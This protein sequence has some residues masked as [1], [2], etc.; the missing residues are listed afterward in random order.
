MMTQD[1]PV[2]FFF[3]ANTPDGFVGFHT[4]D[5]YDPRD[6]WIAYLIKSGAGTGKATFM[7]TLYSELIAMGVNVHAILCSSDPSSLDALLAPD[8]KLCVVDATAPHILE[9]IAY[10]EC[11]QL[12]PFGCCLNDSLT[13][14]TDAWY[15]EADA[16]SAAHARCCRFLAAAARLKENSVRLL[17]GAIDNEK[18]LASAARLAKRELGTSAAVRG[19]CTRRFLSAVTPAGHLFF[20]DTAAAL[21]PRLYVLQDTIGAV[22]TPYMQALCEAA[23]EAGH[24][25][26]ACPCILSPSHIEHLLIPSLG[27][28][29]LTSGPFHTVDFPV[30]RRVHATRF[31]D[32][33]YQR[34]HKGQLRFN[35]RAAASL[36]NE[37]VAASADA[38]IHH[39]RMEQRHVQGMD[40]A[41]WERIA[42]ASKERFLSIVRQRLS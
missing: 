21:C 6:G 32:E 28:G 41:C 29:F 13:E 18:L 3:G 39:D 9:P 42:E 15:E 14:H 19:R 27:V 26:I 31:I 20:S 36:I 7:R 12:V 35:R 16:C 37:A 25:V 38:K 10:G 1:F 4:T 24:D 5:L 23:L 8:L 2:R 33:D 30:Y 11:E 34:A 17:Q 40:W 22:S